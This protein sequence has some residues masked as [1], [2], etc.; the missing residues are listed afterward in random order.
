MEWYC[1]ADMRQQID[2]ARAARDK[3]LIVVMD[4]TLERVEAKA[5]HLLQ[6]V[7]TWTNG[8]SHHSAQLAS[9]R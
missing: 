6:R 2:A 5:L 3:R 9:S 4:Q 8:R 7:R 1:D